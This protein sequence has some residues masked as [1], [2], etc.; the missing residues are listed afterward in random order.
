[1]SVINQMLNDLDKRKTP[2]NPLEGHPY[3]HQA[4]AERDSKKPL[5]V[6]IVVIALLVVVIG[7]LLLERITDEQD[8]VVAPKPVFEQTASGIEDEKAAV[9]ATSLNNNRDNAQ[10]SVGYN[11]TN[12]IKPEP[13]TQLK[14]DENTDSGNLLTS[15][16]ATELTKQVAEVAPKIEQV[17]PKPKK[18]HE[19]TVVA[20]V[21]KAEKA[22]GTGQQNV[23]EGIVKKPAP[24]VAPSAVQDAEQATEKPAAKLSIKRS[25]LS[26][27][28]VAA[29]KVSDA[30]KAT[31]RGDLDKASQLLEQALV[32]EPKNIEAREQLGAL[33]YGKKD[34]KSAINLLKQ[35]IMF[36]PE[37]GQFRILLARIFIEIEQFQLAFNTLEQDKNFADADFQS[38]RA[39]L[40]QQLGQY[41]SAIEA[42]K[43]LITHQPQSSGKWWLGLAIAADKQSKLDIAKQAYQQAITQGGISNQSL[44]FAKKRL[45][46]LG[47]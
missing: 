3:T 19:K 13:K 2:E 35:G 7:Y 26:P 20:V 31:N 15:G 22:P 12:E 11:E 41:D 23:A 44:S 16:Q 27:Q 14:S 33:W 9:T 29:L 47:E 39:S 40:A 45:M 28:E 6:A 21:D 43:Y 46:Q 24:S 38:L 17:V 42:Y 8:L 10:S 32:L 34:Y 37:Y 30:R 36:V 1:M 25:E 18:A 5:L 4:L